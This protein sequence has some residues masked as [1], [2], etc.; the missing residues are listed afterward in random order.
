MATTEPA[1]TQ[2]ESFPYIERDITWLS[3]NYRVLQEAQDARVPLY[4]RIKFLA[5]YSSNLDEFFRVRVSSMRSFKEL[6]KAVRKELQIKP[7]KIL[8]QIHR[9]VQ[10]QQEEFGAIY[11]EQILPELAR[12]RIH[13]IAA[14]QFT[15]AQ[16]DF[17]RAYFDQH[18]SE[19]I[20]VFYFDDGEDIFLQNKALYL[21]VSCDESMDR[22]A[23]V[24]IP[25]DDTNRF[26]KLPARGDEYYLTFLDDIIRHQMPRILNLSDVNGIY[27]V[28]LSRDAEL[29]L[30]DEFSGDLIKK[31]SESLE[32]RNIGLPTRF[33]Y[34]Q[35]MPADLLARVKKY[36]GLSKYDLIPGAR[37]HNFNDFMDFPNPTNDPALHDPPQPPL[38][39]PELE[40]AGS[41]IQAIEGKDRILHFPYQ[42]FHYVPD[43]IDEA[44]ADGDVESI[45]ITLYRVA[46]QSAVGEALVRALNNGKEVTVFIEAKA[47]F[48]EKSNLLW[49][50]RFTEAGATVRYSYPGIKVHTKLLLI[51]RKQNHRQR[52]I[53]YLGTGNF[54]EK[55]AKLYADHALLTADQRLGKEVHRIF[56]MLEGRLIVPRCK[57]LIVSPHR[58]RIAFEELV[59]NEIAQARAG[60]DA[61]MILKM[62]GLEDK[63]MIRKLYEASQAGVQVRM[64]VRGICCLVPGVEGVSENIHVT[65]LVDRYL[66]HARIY[67]FGNAGNP[68][69]YLAS[70]DWM[71][72]NL[73]RRV[74]VVFP[75]YDSDVFQELR[76]ILDLQL[77]DNCK[78]RILDADRH[79]VYVGRDGDGQEVRAQRDIYVLLTQKV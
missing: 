72:R 76:D 55:T 13:L 51:S 24:S 5:I 28:K 54:N 66:E 35:S 48:D 33:L 2:I 19:H 71:T 53:A 11:K 47:R 74:E 73:D 18:I 37:Y 16:S 8:K 32:N 39:H 15:P 1:S 9:I 78:A 40:A 63:G 34:D 68:R 43:L 30:G 38:P 17:S 77:A 79:N 3:F 21:I 45:K 50:N 41:L 27:A 14:E 29:Y 10:D 12:Q 36:L 57:H 58:S 52:Y 67:L 46:M 62:N 69:M 26:V 25:T 7:K 56:E 22:I 20:E 75:V 42:S 65:S 61:W 60:R 4:E 23:V 49:G 6:K 31:I 70:A 64:I 59:D 44:A